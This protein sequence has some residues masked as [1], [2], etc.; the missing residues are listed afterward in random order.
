MAGNGSPSISNVY[1]SMSKFKEVLTSIENEYVDDVDTD[2]LVE[3]A[4]TQMLTKLDPHS[5]YI[6][7][8]DLEV[9]N[10]QLEGNFEGIGIEF[11]IF[12]DTIHVVSPLSGGPSESLG[13]RPGDKI[14]TVDG[15]NVAG[16][17]ITNR[18]VISLLRG[19]KGSEVNVQIKRRGSKDLLDF[20]IERDVIPQFSM[21]VSYMLDENTGYIKI[22]RFSATTYM[23]FKEGLTQLKKS[24]MKNLILDLSGNP[25]GYL[26]EAVK[27]TD[28]LLSDNQMIVYTKGKDS[29]NNDEYWSKEKGDFEEGALIILVDEGSASASEIVTGALQDHDRALV[30]GRRSYGKGLVQKPMA[31]NDGSAMRLTISRY[32]TPSGR[33]IQKPYSEN[34]ED[35]HKELY[36]RFA[37]GEVYNQDSI[38]V[39]DSL[40]YKTDKGRLVYGGGGILPDY[41]VPIDTS[42][43][44]NYLV[45]LFNS[46]SIQEFSLDYSEKHK[47]ELDKWE[48]ESFKKEFKISEEIVNSLIQVGKQ[49]GVKYYDS[50]FKRSEQLIKTYLKAYIARSLWRND[51][52]YPIFNQEN[53]ILAKA[54][55][56]IDEAEK[57]AGE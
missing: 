43:N 21:D 28:E 44:S 1:K 45:R 34:Q 19:Q 7:A 48:I 15:E 31:L 50:D 53:E 37:N 3:N 52:F 22:N 56:L 49:N 38:K 30:V 24:G 17:G 29:R 35:Y 16:T 27:M 13:I 36:D 47:A 42:E 55:T 4:I 9:M 23:E 11:N 26:G 20:L 46:N 33:C 25:G 8:E 10:S 41:F 32:Y 6:P 2:E 57:L 14:V 39:N 40:V 12:H 54:L 18:K 5:V 51:G